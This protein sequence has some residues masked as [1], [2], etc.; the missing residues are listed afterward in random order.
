MNEIRISKAIVDVNEFQ[1]EI[2][3]EN[4][5]GIEIQ[6]FPQ[7]ILDDNYEDL[8]KKYKEKLSRFN[9]LI[10]LHGS[11]FDLN[12]GSTDKRVIE[13]TKYRY[14]QSIE[15]AKEL[16][17]TYVIFHS[18]INPLLRI[19]RI[20]KMKLDNQIKFWKDILNSIRD[21]DI[22]LL[23]ENEYDESPQELLY[24]LK[25]INSN[26]I[27]ACLDTGHALAYSNLS[28]SEWIEELESYIEYIHLHWNSRSC[29]SHNPPPYKE[30]YILNGILNDRNM[31]PIITLEYKIDDIVKEVTRIRGIFT[32]P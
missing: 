20:R 18:Q 22:I 24:M 9:G 30:L 2:F 11:S 5:I 14:L 8:V 17:A 7:H 10:S 25:N 3:E 16:G 15:I 28:I 6:S 26:K 23:I 31:K 1:L 4:N 29:D 32:G 21:T 12:P 27:R 13:L 19:D